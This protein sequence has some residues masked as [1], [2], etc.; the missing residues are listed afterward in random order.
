ME[1]FTLFLFL[2]CFWEVRY[3]DDYGH[4]HE[5]RTCLCT[6]RTLCLWW[7]SLKMP[8]HLNVNDMLWMNKSDC[9][10]ESILKASRIKDRSWEAGELCCLFFPSRTAKQLHSRGQIYNCTNLKTCR[11]APVVKRLHASRWKIADL[12]RSPTGILISIFLHCTH[13]RHCFT[14]LNA[15]PLLLQGKAVL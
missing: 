13:R 6:L 10:S 11:N 12:N 3:G 9:D 8:R 7:A 4:K 5:K 14:I 2:F 1:R 15:W